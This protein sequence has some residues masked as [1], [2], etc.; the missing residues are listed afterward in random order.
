MAKYN[1]N[2]LD[3]TYNYIYSS[4][5]TLQ[6][7]GCDIALQLHFVFISPACTRTTSR[8]GHTIITL[9]LKLFYWYSMCVQQLVYVY[10]CRW[11]A[12]ILLY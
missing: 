6:W 11:A 9:L 12:Q 8:K 3:S 1:I 2:H 7:L 4:F 5:V 10:N